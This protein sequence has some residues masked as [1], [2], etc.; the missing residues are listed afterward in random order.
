MALR[1]DGDGW[2]RSDARAVGENRPWSAAP[3]ARPGIR[4]RTG[5]DGEAVP[6]VE[7]EPVRIP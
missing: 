7:P 4:A 3:R 2:L 5:E 1:R 6:E